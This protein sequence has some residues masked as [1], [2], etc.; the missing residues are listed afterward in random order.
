MRLLRLLPLLLT[1]VVIWALNRSFGNTPPLGKLLD[2]FSGCLTAAEPVG[3]DFSAL[4]TVKGL[5]HP[6]DIWLEDRLVPHIRAQNDHDLYFTEG[7]L[8]AT[9]RLWQMDFQTRAAAGRLGEVIGAKWDTDKTTGK[10][11]NLILQYDRGQRR[12]GMIYA[13]ERSLQAM[14]AEPRTKAMLDAYRNGINAFIHS[15]SYR[16]YPLEYKLMDFAPE[17]W[18]NLKSALMLKFMA[19]DLTGHSDD[20]ANTMLRD[21]L[22]QKEFDFLFP[23]K[24]SGSKPVIPEGTKFDAPSLAAPKYPGDSV[25]A[26]FGSHQSATVNGQSSVVGRQ[27]AD[28]NGQTANNSALQTATFNLQTEHSDGIGSN[29]WAISGSHTASGK[30]ILCNDPHLG[31]NLP[32][33]WF[34]AQLTAPGVNVYGATLPGAPGVVIGFNNHISWGFTNNYR[35]VKDYYE[36]SEADRNHYWFNGKAQAYQT[37][38]ERIGIKGSDD[39]VDTVRYTIHG[40]VQYEPA[41][42]DA[43]NSGKTLAM[44]WMA[45]RPT[46]EL[47]SI[48]LLNRAAD[49][50]TFTAAIQHFECPAQNFAYADNSG[51][52]AMWGQGQFINK[53]RGQ[54]RYVMEGRDSLTLWGQNIPMAENPHVLNPPQG[55]VASANQSVTDSTYPYWYNG[56]FVEWRS[57]RINNILGQTIRKYKDRAKISLIRNVGPE[58]D[59]LTSDLEADSYPNLNMQNL[60][61]DVG[62]LINSIL[63]K[64]RP[65]KK[66]FPNEGNILD[67]SNDNDELDDPTEQNLFFSSTHATRIQIWWY[68]LYKD[69]WQDDFTNKAT[70][71]PS[72]ERTV[73]LLL[74]DSTSKY[75]DDIRTPQKETLRDIVKRALNEAADSLYKLDASG[76][77]EW[78][79]V[80][81]TTLTHLARIPAFSYDHLKIGGW[82]NTINAASGNHGPSWRMIVEMDSIPKAYA[83]YPGGQSGNP[84]SEHYGDYIENWVEGKYFTLHFVTPAVTKNPFKYT[85]TLKPAS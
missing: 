23:E 77:R 68:N 62:S 28:G 16:K 7:Y 20:I 1:L 38:M 49:Y 57:W 3:K 83:V 74:S 53:W 47:L 27:L 56:D 24:I 60:Q 54:G 4:A 48:Y 9:F 78:Y 69:I 41:F 22:G 37:R 43:A 40:P 72:S 55:Y 59:L 13:A 79:K 26:R 8:H 46:N 35:D 66:K 51:N 58:F 50:S 32:S 12:K 31:L 81:N 67:P 65:I 82:N 52:I 71:W 10:R 85:L 30:P 70:I 19:D 45:H 18:T 25:W 17:D 34:E 73:Q 2:P 80:K 33:L 63:L 29:N 15:L 44:C 42:P 5:Q 76:G 84:G 6:V 64:P 11:V 14:E 21:Q 61:N 39:F 75:Y 36:I